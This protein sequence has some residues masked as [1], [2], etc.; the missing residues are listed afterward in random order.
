MLFRSGSTWLK[1][2]TLLCA[3]LAIQPVGLSASQESPFQRLETAGAELVKDSL[4][5]RMVR[6]DRIEPVTVDMVREMALERNLDIQISSIRGKRAELEEVRRDAVFDTEL[7]LS[8]TYTRKDTYARGAEIGRSRRIS[9]GDAEEDFADRTDDD[10]EFNDDSVDDDNPM[11]VYIDGVLIN[12]AQCKSQYAYSVETEMASYE[13]HDKRMP[14]VAVGTFS[15]SRKFLWGQA[16]KLD[17]QSRWEEKKHPSIGKY[18]HLFTWD[19]GV[20][21]YPYGKNPWTSSVSLNLSTPLPFC[22]NFGEDGNYSAVLRR[23]SSLDTQGVKYDHQAQAT[24]TLAQTF[25]SWWDLAGALARL[26]VVVK[27]RT[28]LE[29]LEARTTKLMEAGERTSYALIQVSA[30]LQQ[31][32]AAEESAWSEY[33]F[34]SNRL[35]ELLDMDQALLFFPVG[36]AEAIHEKSAEVP[37]NNEGLQAV[38]LSR[39]EL[40]AADIDLQAKKTLQTYYRSGLLPDVSLYFTSSLSQSSAYWGYGS[41]YESAKHITEPDSTNFYFGFVYTLPIGDRAAESSYSQSRIEKEKSRLQYASM[42]NSIIREI[43]KAGTDIEA[44]SR[45][46]EHARQGMLFKKLAYEKAVELSEDD[47]NITEF[48]LLQKFTEYVTT[49]LL[50][51]S[52]AVNWQK[53][54]VDALRAMGQ[55]LPEDWKD[56]PSSEPEEEA[57]S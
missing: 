47:P 49:E 57:H 7:G 52:S 28:H 50:F 40:K 42:K 9:G 24:E 25:R 38:A 15:L 36:F 17:F 55:L 1:G 22:K 8:G 45:S 35:A 19:D 10:D 41:W 44:N 14:E 32:R 21:G 53:A 54:G 26:A 18:S 5:N 12:P 4:Y 11:C 20:D 30:A 39:P 46:M 43:R 16:L 48:Q 33:R 6:K 27:A 51:I 3:L 31:W 23:I 13:I 29:E 34:V 56:A 2:I 37:D